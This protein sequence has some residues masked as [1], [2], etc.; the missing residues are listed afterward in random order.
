MTAPIVRLAAELDFDAIAAI[1]NH[2]IRTTAVHFG[3]EDVTAAEL[4][5]LWRMHVELYPWL[6]VE[7][8]RTIAGYAKAGPFRA[9][10]AYRN[11]TETG[12][13]LRPD[14]RGRGFGRPLYERL[15]DVLRAQGFHAVVGGIALP[16][17]VSVK[18]HERLGFAAAGIVR[19]AGY[20]FERW[21]DVGF[22]QLMLR[23]G[24]VTAA[25][26]RS[27]AEAFASL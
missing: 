24:A 18:L 21:H 20:K 19:E 8:D 7:V 16:N 26:L 9:R 25:P 10:D 13:Y 23:P 12:I 6:V 5:D 22:W 2:Y 1:T 11:I 27:P 15:L 4:R 14:H 3:Y 17:D